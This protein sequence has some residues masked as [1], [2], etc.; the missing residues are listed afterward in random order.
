MS[1]IEDDEDSNP[2]A[3]TESEVPPVTP[4]FGRWEGGTCEEFRNAFPEW[5]DQYSEYCSEYI[6]KYVCR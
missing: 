1:T 5:P 6:A 2:Y 4:E 3:V